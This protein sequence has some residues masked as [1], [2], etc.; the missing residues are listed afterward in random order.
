[1]LTLFEDA[2]SQIVD[3]SGKCRAFIFKSSESNL[4]VFVSPLPPLDL[5]ITSEIYRCSA[6]DA[7]AFLTKNDINV[8]FQDSDGEKIQGLWLDIEKKIPSIIYAYI[9]IIVTKKIDGILDAPEN[10]SDPLRTEKKSLLNE[11]R[12]SKKVASVLMEYILLLYANDPD[13]FGNRSEKKFGH[14]KFRIDEGHVYT[15]EEITKILTLDSSLL[16][17]GRLIV[18]STVVRD[19]LLSFLRVCLLNDEYSVLDTKNKKQIDGWYS[20]VEDF[21]ES[22][23][24]LIFLEREGLKRW[25]KSVEGDSKSYIRQQEHILCETLQSSSLTEPYF[26]KGENNRIAIIQNVQDGELKRALSVSEKWI[27]DRINDG[28]HTPGT[29]EN[30]GYTLYDIKS[31]VKKKGNGDLSILL[32]PDGKHAALLFT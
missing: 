11:Y 3:N 7:L 29:T 4:S 1:M 12:N 16:K 31:V 23:N 8:A 10:L 17:R 2:Q 6:K 9:P 27:R 19:R 14:D 22:P 30:L 25:K 13:S 5:P 21:R 28:Y 32:Y 18:P 26:W 24:S 20:G 15:D